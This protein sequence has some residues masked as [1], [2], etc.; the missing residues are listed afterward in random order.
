MTLSVINLGMIKDETEL[1]PLEEHILACR[2]CATRAE[3]AQDYVD[4]MRVAAL[5]LA[6][7]CEGRMRFGADAIEPR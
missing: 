3:Q 6:D 7:P 5:D 4:A 2:S 1:G